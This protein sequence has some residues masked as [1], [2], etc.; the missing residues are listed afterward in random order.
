LQVLIKPDSSQPGVNFTPDM[1]LLDSLR[2]GSLQP[3]VRVSSGLTLTM[4][5]EADR[6]QPAAPGH[7]RDRRREALAVASP[8]VSPAG[9]LHCGR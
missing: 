5:M 4:H 6:L 1:V 3:K 7:M 8:A 2:L 9:L